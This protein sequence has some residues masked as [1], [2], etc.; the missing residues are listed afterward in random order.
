MKERLKELRK[1]LDLSQQEFADKIGIKR[2]TIANYEVGRNEPI[3]AVVSLIC[4]K[5]N[6]SENWL[7]TGDGEM[8]PPKDRLDEIAT[9]TSDLFNSE[10]ESFKYRLI[11]AISKMSERDL[12]A[13]EKLVIELTKK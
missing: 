10:P 4:E 1:A 12:E 7:R 11:T 13:L 9:I 5:F 6:V 2:G 8:F 3:D